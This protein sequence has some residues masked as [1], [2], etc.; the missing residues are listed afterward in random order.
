MLFSGC[1]I[2]R[3]PPPPPEIMRSHIEPGSLAPYCSFMILAHS[4]RP[5]RNFATCSN[6]LPKRSK[7]YESRPANSSTGTPRLITS[8]AYARAMQNAHAISC[9]GVAPDSRMW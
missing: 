5:A 6:R 8:S 9:V 7:L 2:V 3:P 1:S 4:P